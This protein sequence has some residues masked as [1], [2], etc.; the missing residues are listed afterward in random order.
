MLDFLLFY[1][2]QFFY[3][4][5]PGDVTYNNKFGRVQNFAILQ[6]LD[7]PRKLIHET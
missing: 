7:L 3:P 2:V 5:R 1:D 4:L 6:I